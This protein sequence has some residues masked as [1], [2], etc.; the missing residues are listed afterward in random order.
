[1]NSN[2]KENWNII[3]E[4]SPISNI[5]VKTD[6]AK[7]YTIKNIDIIAELDKRSIFPLSIILSK[8]FINKKI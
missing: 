7:L 8:Q 1:M 2:P 6:D 5:S 4:F 3:R